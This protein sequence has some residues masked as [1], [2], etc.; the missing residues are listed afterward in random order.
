MGRLDHVL[1]QSQFQD[2]CLS[3]NTGNR[4]AA[5]PEDV[6]DLLEELEAGIQPSGPWHCVGYRPCSPINEHAVDSKRLPSA[7]QGLGDGADK[8]SGR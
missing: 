7:R 4:P 5:A 1:A 6:D 8:A 2:R 3:L